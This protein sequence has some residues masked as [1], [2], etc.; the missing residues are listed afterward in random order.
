MADNARMR[1]RL[2]LFVDDL[3]RSVAFYE[4]ALGFRAVR[5]EPAYVSLRRGDAELGLAPVATLP[6]D[7]PGPGFTQ[8]RLAGIRGAGAEIVLE[9]EDLDAALRAVERAGH[10]LAEPLRDRPWGLRDFRVA[11]PD[12]S[13]VRITQPAP[14]QGA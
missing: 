1:L 8:D 14:A 7:G 3:D 6:A 5:R 2:E 10:P 11:D 4:Q 12:G 9:V 13:Y